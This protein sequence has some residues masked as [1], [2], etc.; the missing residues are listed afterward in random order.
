[1][2]KLLTLSAIML[3]A[4]MS[5]FA[6]GNNGSEAP[7]GDGT[8]VY[9]PGTETSV[10]YNGDTSYVKDVAGYVYNNTKAVVHVYTDSAESIEHEIVIGNTS[11]AITEKAYTA[12][13]KRI[14]RE[15]ALY[16]E[17][18]AEAEWDTV[19]Y[20]VYS[21]G[22]SVAI[23]WSDERIHKSPIWESHIIESLALDFFTENYLNCKTLVLEE[24]YVKT[25][26]FSIT[27][28]LAERGVRVL[29]EKWNLLEEQIPEKYR[30]D[31]ISS[32][33][34]LY[35]LYDNRMVSWYA[36]LYDPGIGGWYWSNSGRDTVGYLPS[37]EET[38]EAVNFVSGSG[39]AE[40]FDDKW[41]DALPQWL[42]DQIGNFIYNLQDEDG[43]FYHPQWPKEYIEANGLQSRITRDVGSAK[44]VLGKLGI[45][46]KY[47]GTKSASSLT[48]ELGSSKVVAVS[49]VVPTAMLSQFES[50]EAFKKYLD[51]FDAELAN[52][53]DNDS[54]AY[55]FYYYGNLFQSTT[56]YVNS[57]PEFRRMLIEFF[58]KHQNPETGLWAAEP[59]YN[60]TNAI[61][62]IGSVYNSIGAELKYVDKMVDATIEILLFDMETKPSGA[63]V[64]VYN[65]WSCFPYIYQ[66]IRKCSANP[67]VGEAKCREIKDRVYSLAK[68]M[69]DNTALHIVGLKRDDGSFSYSRTGVNSTAQ[70]CPISVPGVVEGN[71][72]GNSIASLAVIQ[73]I[74][75]ALELE[76]YEVPLFTE[77][78]RVQFVRILENL[79][80]VIKDSEEL[81][82]DVTYDLEDVPIGDL[83]DGFESVLDAGRNP[84]EGSFV[85]VSEEGETG[86]RV[87]ELSAKHRGTDANGRN[88]A[89]KFPVERIKSHPNVALLEFDLKV[90]DETD[91]TK[92][93]ELG[94][95]GKNGATNIYPMFNVKSDG[96]IEL[97]DYDGD[98]IATIGKLNEYNSIKIE[99]YWNEGLYKV[100]VNGLYRGTGD[101]SYSNSHSETTAIS[102][103]TSSTI[104][105]HYYL[106]NIRAVSLN[107]EY[108]DGA[109][110]LADEK[111]YSFDDLT[112]PEDI[113]VISGEATVGGDAETGGYLSLNGAAVKIPSN[114]RSYSATSAIIEAD[115]KSLASAAS[116][117]AYALTL[118]NSKDGILFN[119]NIG[120]NESG[121][122][123]IYD[124]KSFDKVETNVSA[125]E[126]TKVK[127]VYYWNIGDGKCQLA[128]EVYIGDAEEP[129]ALSLVP[130]TARYI[131]ALLSY[132]TITAN[133]AS[134]LDNIRVENSSA[135]FTAPAIPTV[136]PGEDSE[137]IDFEDRNIGNDV[138]ARI[139]GDAEIGA[140]LDGSNRYLMITD[141]DKATQKNVLIYPYGDREGATH[142]FFEF[143]IEYLNSTLKKLLDFHILGEDGE[144]EHVA[145]LMGYSYSG[146]APHIRMYCKTDGSKFSMIDSAPNVVDRTFYLKGERN[147]SSATKAKV[148]IAIDLESGDL[149]V[150]YRGQ[151]SFVY[152]GIIDFSVKAL[153]LI[154]GEE[155]ASTLTIDNL[156]ARFLDASAVKDPTPETFEGSYVT[157]E[158]SWD[159]THSGA[160]GLKSSATNLHF[161]SGISVT[162]PTGSYTNLHGA[163]VEVL[164][165]NGNKYLNM[166]APKRANDRDRAH[167]LAMYAE[168]CTFTP[169]AY[170]YEI[171]LKLDSVLEDG[172]S[173]HKN[174]LQVIFRNSK[175]AYVQY[176]MLGKTSGFVDLQGIPLAN[177]DEWF[178]LRLEY[179]PEAEKIQ[180]YVKNAEGGYDYRG[181][182]DEAMASSSGKGA[183][184]AV[185]EGNVSSADIN[186]ANT[187]SAG[188][189]FNLDNATLS[190]TKLEYKADQTPV[191]PEENETPGEGGGEDPVDP[192][193][194]GD[195]DQPN[196]PGGGTVTPPA[197]EPDGVVK[198]ENE[199]DYG[200]DLPGNGSGGIIDDDLDEWTD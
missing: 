70:G 42:K 159:C 111:V 161:D 8:H 108:T 66:N 156:S 130:Y 196:T 28:Y 132:A 116:D 180:V 93:I 10:I 12:L 181:D 36:N 199:P 165:E 54:W 20:A 61:H 65:A 153:K 152:S 75:K 187:S 195:P 79:Q 157:E 59:C 86:N 22:K 14:Q 67:E 188:F 168:S 45:T 33:K 162:Y 98:F 127:L 58:D 106:D 35:A 164:E 143:D 15:V 169:N 182:L 122:Y 128:L 63:G 186:G 99:Y 175:G 53:T 155:S 7:S 200:G 19:G 125:I 46:P 107:K 88:N 48:G 148:Q 170:V 192:P 151:H 101:S 39:M 18:E 198:D 118:Y 25:E 177:W 104:N 121:K 26:I 37:I 184:P 83:P 1:M 174:Y 47:S 69:I 24:G 135:E 85:K 21:D 44:T 56:S 136:T 29:N 90:L 137:T 51:G 30:E 76:E 138:P 2:K 52:I 190:A 178:T 9:A 71:V 57:N 4:V 163:K 176:N 158:V 172:T 78:E 145:Q 55:K 38:Y 80:P 129:I 74:M 95:R 150:T 43:F 139:T 133:T 77:A 167:S 113:T 123:Y 49:K 124:E 120:I 115:L 194:G 89:L 50:V 81:G 96:T 146:P 73:H 126:S 13:S 191:L 3:I 32:L 109:L 72:N 142:L 105:S 173:S 166:T 100:Y 112:L 27:D 17:D 119:V 103:G 144:S 87:I 154:T 40:L 68:A 91:K 140:E 41:E 147:V 11:R 197:V 193:S 64:D 82:R 183:S 34:S 92:V 31:I 16:V 60:A 171:D 141:P 114:I 189:S 97:Y 185:L 94:F 84:I 6:C 102:F 5:L 179:H 110:E 134:T 62:K 160:L 149:T 131:D 23:V 117:K